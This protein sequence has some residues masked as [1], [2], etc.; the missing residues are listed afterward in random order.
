MVV[1]RWLLRGVPLYESNRGQLYHN[2]EILYSRKFSPGIIFFFFT[3]KF[4]DVFFSLIAISDY[5]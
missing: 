4:M 1:K 3:G 5:N 2:C